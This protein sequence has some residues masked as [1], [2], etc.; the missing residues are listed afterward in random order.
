MK[1]TLLL[2]ATMVLAAAAGAA[3]GQPVRP[4]SLSYMSRLFRLNDLGPFDNP[5]FSRNGKW[6]AFD[7]QSKNAG[8]R[9]IFVVAATG[10][11][12]FEITGG[13]QTDARPMWTAAGDR[14][15]FIS[16][17][18]SAVMTIA[19]DPATGRAT[20]PAKRVTIDSLRGAAYD[21]APDGRSVAYLTATGP[22]KYDVRLVPINGGPAKTLASV[23][24]LAGQLRFDGDGS[25]IYFALQRLG[26]AP[27]KGVAARDVKRVATTGGAP[28]TVFTI[29]D[30]LMGVQIDPIANRV[31]VRDGDRQ[32]VLTLAGDSVVTF[33]WPRPVSTLAF[34]GDGSSMVT[35][36]DATQTSI[37]LVPLDGGPVRA[38][39]DTTGYPWP[40]YWI[41][42]NIFVS[43]ANHGVQTLLTANGTKRTITF[44]VRKANDDVPAGVVN[45]DP[46]SDGVH[47]AVQA[48]DASGD[49]SLFV[50]DSRSGSARRVAQKVT[51]SRIL[52]A[53]GP[54]DEYSTAVGDE[55]L[56][57]NVRNGVVE[58]HAVD[59]SGRDRI[60][61]S[62]PIPKQREEL[63][64]APGRMAHVYQRADT[65]YLDV[66]FGSGRPVHVLARPG[67]TLSDIVFNRDG[68][69]LYV[70]VYV[71]TASGEDAK[72]RGA[73]FST[74]DARSLSLPPRWVE[75]GD[76]W[77]PTWLP[78]DAGVLES[79]ENQAGTQTWVARIPAS[80][81]TT[82]QTLTQREAAVFWDYTMSPDGKYVAVPAVRSAGM[83]VW[84][85]DLRVAAKG[86]SPP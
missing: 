83:N 54:V 63:A 41:G 27:A 10:G 61:Y 11:T 70:Y 29:P 65:G 25:H 81:P 43:G 71:K 64:F 23:E 17:A 9:H 39:T 3:R 45:F 74:A 76:C 6:L 86:Q 18:S 33:T 16:V 85:V 40:D 66:T 2:R 52:G 48:V 4:D 57:R 1:P 78:G 79:C 19:V 51:G 12:P 77:H 24:G 35:A 75:T 26:P 80:G 5:R 73:F 72:Q 67:A 20:G 46:F 44:D 53:V 56:Y 21:V 60:A 22:N 42:E 50:Y 15:V 84:R 31:L 36:V 55:F 47:Y 34:S 69:S 38:L 37:H 59:V 82:P 13:T 62:S 68:S 32:H 30:G 28:T 7:G 14:L 58:V 49:T 8:G